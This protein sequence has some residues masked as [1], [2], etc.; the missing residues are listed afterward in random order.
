MQLRWPPIIAAALVLTAAAPARAE[1]AFGLFLGEPTGL[2]LEIGL[3][4]RS[5]LDIVIGETSFRDGRSGYGHLTYLLTPIVARGSSVDVPIRLG[6]G[7]ALYGPSGDLGLAARAP[8]EL[9][10][11]FRSAPLELYGEI[12]LAVEVIGPGADPVLD[13]QG[14]VGLRVLL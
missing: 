4:H 9:G 11:R 14:G 8:F 13:V 7:A 3:D 1:L 5:A 12:A 6:I 10:L 2:D